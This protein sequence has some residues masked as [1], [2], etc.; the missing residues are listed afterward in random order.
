MVRAC[1]NAHHALAVL[2]HCAAPGGLQEGPLG[3]QL[4]ELP[5]GR[6]DQGIR[7]RLVNPSFAVLLYC[8]DLDEAQPGFEPV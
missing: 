1:L 7:A 6:I 5:D 2:Q 3:A 8:Q 4:R